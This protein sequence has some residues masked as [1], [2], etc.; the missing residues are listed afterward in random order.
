MTSQRIVALTSITLTTLPTLSSHEGVGET[1]GGGFAGVPQVHQPGLALTGSGPT[2]ASLELV[3]P[4]LRI[5]G[6]VEATTEGWKGTLPLHASRWGSPALPPPSGTYRLLLGG[7]GVRRDE[8]TTLPEAQ[9]VPD[10]FRLTIGLR[11]GSHTTIT[12]SPPLTDEEVGASNQS[13]LEAHYRSTKVEPRAAVFF[14]SFYGQNASCN[15]LALDR[16]IAQLRPDVTR[17]W[18][19]AD[20]SVDIP[21]GAIRV[22]EGSALW[23]EARAHARLIVVNDWLRNKFRKRKHQTVLQTW[24]GTM[25]K[26]LALSRSR[27]GL[28]PALATLRERSRWDILLAQND[29]AARIFR[30]AYAYFGAIWEEGYPRDD[31]LLTADPA[32]IRARLGIP[33]GVRVLLY[34]PTWRDDRPDHVDHLDVSHFAE[35]LGVGFVTLIRGHSRTLQPGTDLQAGGV[36]DVTS[37]PD[38]T[39]L[40]VTADAL[41]TDY[42]SVMFDFSVTGK[43]IFFFT[44]DLDRYQQVLRGFYFDLLPVAPGPVVQSADELVEMVRTTDAVLPEFAEKYAAWQKRFNPHDDGGAAQRVVTR[45]IREGRI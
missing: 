37:Y 43:P 44:P 24:H 9:L 19:V 7:R 10:Q 4:R 2:P 33:A 21:D 27:V 45:L 36:I 11:K 17:Y 31:A 16:A 30:R 8:R 18:A 42:S 5:T 13:R 3:G 41:I 23:W 26:K 40:F 14:E 39:D 34:A 35:A 6:I 1:P 38:I 25:L 12:F 15:P 28:R 20:S 32:A 22:V 29:Y